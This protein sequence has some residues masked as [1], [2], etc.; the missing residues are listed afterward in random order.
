MHNRGFGD[1]TLF[2]RLCQ[3]VT[4]YWLLAI[5]YWLLAIDDWRQAPGQKLAAGVDI[6]TAYRDISIYGYR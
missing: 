5:G 4:V 3:Q 1:L 6:V 2:Y